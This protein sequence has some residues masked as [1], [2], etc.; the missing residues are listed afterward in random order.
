MGPMMGGQ[1]AA[2]AMTGEME[3]MMQLCAQMMGQMAPPSGAPSAPGPRA[4]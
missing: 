2:P 4:N 1:A 3:R